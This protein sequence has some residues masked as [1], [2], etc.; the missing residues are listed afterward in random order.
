MD[1]RNRR[2]YPRGR[3]SSESFWAHEGLPPLSF[4]SDGTPRDRCGRVCTLAQAG[5]A[6]LRLSN[7]K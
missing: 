7:M 4:L 5:A 2:S 1:L 6:P 3:Y